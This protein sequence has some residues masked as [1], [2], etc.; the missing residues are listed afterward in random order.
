MDKC[1]LSDVGSA[2]GCMF[3]CLRF[4]VERRFRGKEKRMVVCRYEIAEDDVKRTWQERRR[5]AVD[6]TL[7]V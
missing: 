7:V 6:V 1:S 5:D 4:G 2:V 3:M